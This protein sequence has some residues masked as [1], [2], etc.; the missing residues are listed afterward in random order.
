[1]SVEILVSPY[2]ASYYVLIIG[3]FKSRRI[4][5]LESVALTW[6]KTNASRV[7]V[8]KPEEKRALDRRK[9]DGIV[10]SK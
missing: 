5:W 6:N 9:V 3:F 1:M 4:T 10:I 7:S 2:S 8:E